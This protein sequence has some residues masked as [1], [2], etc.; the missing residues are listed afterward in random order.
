MATVQYPKG[1]SSWK[2]PVP[3]DYVEVHRWISA[4]E[5]RIWL[6]RG[7]THIP[8]GLADIP[9]GLGGGSRIHVTVPGAANPTPGNFH[10]VE[11]CIPAKAL[12]PGGRDDWRLIFAPWEN[13]PIYNVRIVSP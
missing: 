10:R 5:V 2:G 11:F 7:G 4:N 8:S 6:E 9:G 13:I 12:Q 3:P 1:H